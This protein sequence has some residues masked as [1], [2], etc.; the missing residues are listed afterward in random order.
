MFSSMPGHK[1]AKQKA[2]VSFTRLAR[3]PVEMTVIVHLLTERMR[4]LAGA[5]RSIIFHCSRTQNRIDSYDVVARVVVAAFVV[6]IA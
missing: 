2:F 1:V 3:I 5:R 6:V 4:R